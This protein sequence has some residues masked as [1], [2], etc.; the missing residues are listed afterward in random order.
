[1]TRLR[2]VL[3]ILEHRVCNASI[4]PMNADSF[5]GRFEILRDDSGFTRIV[6]QFRY[7]RLAAMWRHLSSRGL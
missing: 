6:V 7:R 3:A 2:I 4:G 5:G 1:M